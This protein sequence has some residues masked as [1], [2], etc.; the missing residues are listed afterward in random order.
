MIKYPLD[1]LTLNE[2]ISHIHNNEMA[3]RETIKFLTSLIQDAMEDSDEEE[4]WYQNADKF[5]QMQHELKIY[6]ENR[7]FDKNNIRKAKGMESK[8][9]VNNIH[10]SVAKA[11]APINVCGFENEGKLNKIESEFG[12]EM[13]EEDLSKHFGERRKKKKDIDLS[14]KSP[15]KGMTNEEIS[16]WENK[17]DNS[18]NLYKIKARVVNLARESGASISPVGEMLCNTFVHV[19][20]DLY[21]FAETIQDKEVKIQLIEKIRKHESMPA[22]LIKATVSGV[23]IK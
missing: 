17:Q 18:N 12:G 6:H 7:I 19:V 3:Q 13:S 21:D 23:K 20:K 4:E 5:L 15:F 22:N 8:V 1:Q 14:K 10:H 2:F 16:E 11:T 9:P